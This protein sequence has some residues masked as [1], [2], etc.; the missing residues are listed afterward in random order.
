VVGAS[1]VYDALVVHRRRGPTGHHFEQRVSLPLVD[2]AELPSLC[3][4]SPWW[5]DRHAAPIRF[6]RGD[7][8]GPAEVPLDQAVR[9]LV[10]ERTGRRPAGPVRLLAHLRT[11]GWN[12]NPLACYFCF[13]QDGRVEA[14]V[15]EVTNTPWHERH[16]YVVGPPGE[17]RM[18]KALHVSPFFG[19]DQEYRFSYTAPDERLR[20]A[21][22]VVQEGAVVFGASLTGRRRPLDRA[23]QRRLA[24]TPWRSSPAVSS[25]I[26]R[27]ALALW[28]AGVPIQRHPS[29]PA[30]SPATGAVADRPEADPTS[31]D[32]TSGVPVSL[33]SR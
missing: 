28:R 29:R 33:G 18:A 8:L 5:S 12:F 32:R 23:A 27:Q 26:Y 17:H 22:S 15:A 20:V 7:F 2:L 9:D 4:A 21:I 31:P 19:M 24:L 16:A 13:D 1:A 25:G 10:E 14:M 11:W 3:A 30:P 6:V